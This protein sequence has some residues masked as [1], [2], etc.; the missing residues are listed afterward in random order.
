MV[1]ESLESLGGVK[2]SIF[3]IADVGDRLIKLQVT[4]GDHLLDIKRAQDK[5]I[6]AEKIQKE[7]VN[8]K[9]G[10]RDLNLGILMTADSHIGSVYF[11][12]GNALMKAKRWKTAIA[13]F[14][15]CIKYKYKAGETFLFHHK[16]GQCYVKRKQ[17]SKG[18]SSFETALQLLKSSTLGEKTKTDFTKI[19]TE[20]ISKF[21][22]KKDEGVQC[23]PEFVP[24]KPCK[25]DPR[26]TDQ[27]EIIETIGMGRN[28]FAKDNI[29]VGSI[30]AVVDT[31]GAHLNPDKPGQI[32]KYCLHCMVGVEVPY[33]CSS[34]PRVIF[35]GPKCKQEAEDSYHKYEC[36]MDLYNIRINDSKDGCTIF[37][38]I[39]I[40]CGQPLKFWIQN[41]KEFLG[42]GWS[43]DWP[44]PV[45]SDVQRLSL[46]FQMA[47]NEEDVSAATHARHSL[48]T[49]FL[50]R[51]LRNT[52]YYSDSGVET[53]S[54][55]L[56][57][58]EVVIGKL[59]YM[60]RLIQDMN[61]HPVWGVGKGQK[62]KIG[63]DHIGAGLYSGIG[64][65]FNSDCNPN[66]FRI[67]IGRKMLLIACKNIRKGEEVMD[68]YCI[69][70][71]ELPKHIRNPWI[72]EHYLF[73]CTCQACEDEWPTYKELNKDRPNK[74]VADKLVQLEM[75]NLDFVEKGLIDK[76]IESHKQ[77]IRLIQ[78]GLPTPHQL[79][80]AVMKSFQVCWWKKV[81]HYLQQKDDAE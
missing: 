11:H 15:L 25:Q 78:T 34:C 71:S 76:A 60:L 30:L 73:D 45:H 54:G 3:K 31:E 42:N 44:A 21:K 18:V 57:P 80:V 69:N 12:R 75:D 37:H 51:A 68:N 27:V 17:Y 8:E 35:C 4:L 1:T 14:Q 10:V 39:K 79:Q 47:K 55:K 13:D 64:S 22:N 59:I 38:S 9:S 43:G 23:P 7:T 36:Q 56:Q 62:E 32:M 61:S 67:N 2:N 40:I 5:C 46:L 74:K 50:L 58:G 65:Y 49:I 6:K 33:P 26:V 81:V 63:H 29:Q 28:A 19:L 77:E 53:P 20:C 41:Q 72:K 70:F 52:T 16:I 24:E 48:V 66:T